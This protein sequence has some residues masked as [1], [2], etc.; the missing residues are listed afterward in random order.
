MSGSQPHKTGSSSSAT[1]VPA[2]QDTRDPRRSLKAAL[3]PLMLFVSSMLMAI[4]WLGH[5]KFKDA[6]FLVALAVA[7]LIVLPE[8]A[9]NVAAVR[10]GKGIYRGA[11][12]A[13]FNLC[14]GVVCVVFVSRFVL[15]ETLEPRQYAGFALML[16]A[17]LLIGSREHVDHLP[18]LEDD[19]A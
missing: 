11:T 1:G 13:S 3:V 19:P 6:H 18:I 9:L 2:P 10:M 7:W 15:D 8:Y 12:M 16:V 4:A 5:L 17:M 14:T